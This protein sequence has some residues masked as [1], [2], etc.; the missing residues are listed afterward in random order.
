MDGMITI[1]DFACQNREGRQ[2]AV[3]RAISSGFRDT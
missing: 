1:P 3:S 2:P